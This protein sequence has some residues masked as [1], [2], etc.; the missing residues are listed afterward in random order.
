MK[1]GV[2]HANVGIDRQRSQGKRPAKD[3]GGAKARL[4][5]LAT[6]PVDLRLQRVSALFES[7]PD[8]SETVETLPNYSFPDASTAGTAQRLGP[9]NEAIG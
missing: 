5:E 1:C 4:A 9:C 6:M 8:S 2:V 3:R 7:C